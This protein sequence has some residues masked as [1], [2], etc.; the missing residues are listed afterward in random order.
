ME[1]LP[2]S[3]SPPPPSFSLCIRGAKTRKGL[4]L[5]LLLMAEGGPSRRREVSDREGRG[6][7]VSGAR[8]QHWETRQKLS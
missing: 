2:E 7:E 3:P 8:E 6:V 5:S 4:E 1:T